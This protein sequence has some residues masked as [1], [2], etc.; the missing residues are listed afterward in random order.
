[1]FYDENGKKI[2]IKKHETTEQ[3]FAKKYIK[4]DDTVLELGG[5]YGTVSY[6]INSIL[7]NSK[8]LIVV[9]PDNT[10]WDALEN[11]KRIN[12]CNFNIIKGIISNENGNLVKHGYG[13]RV[14]LKNKEGILVNNFSLNEIKLKYNIKNFTVL[15]VDC[16]GCFE[17]FIK[18]NETILDELRLILI[19]YDMPKFCNYENVEN[20]LSKKGFKCTVK[21]FHN[22]WEKVIENFKE[23]ID[24]LNIPLYYIGF[25]KNISLEQSLKTLGFKNINHFKAIDGRKYDVNSLYHNNII[26]IRSYNDLILGRE[27]DSGLP[28]LGAVG[29]TMSHYTL[30][31]K[32]LDD[33]LPFMIILEEDV[34]IKSFS[35]KVQ[36]D[37]IKTI[38]KPNSIFLSPHYLNQLK[39]TPITQFWGTSF[40]IVSKGACQ[41]LVKYAYPID[42]QTDYY[43]A[44]LD[45]FKK[46]NV[47]GYNITMC[48]GRPS[49][50]QTDFFNNKKY[51]KNKYGVTP[52]I[53]IYALV[54]L[55]FLFFIVLIN[56]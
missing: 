39:K 29:C 9:E 11:N 34:I 56:K 30:W 12:N 1:M 52:D 6:V 31:K 53:F 28:S 17:N 19:E 24:L 13:T 49:T 51:G 55:L 48:D 50:I 18:E 37:I 7:D 2:D 44:H 46:I 32:C 25:T 38:E 45:T 36:S 26:N 4:K 47:E 22:V 14:D 21:G 35:P 8:N 10:V 16:E 54:I 5:R 3:E 33:D 41:Q 43:I 20:I 42:V 27:Q 23:K 15:V 40:Y